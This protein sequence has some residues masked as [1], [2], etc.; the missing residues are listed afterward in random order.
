MAVADQP[1]SRLRDAAEAELAYGDYWCRQAGNAAHAGRT[2]DETADLNLAISQLNSGLVTVPDDIAGLFNLAQAY[3]RMGLIDQQR[4]DRERAAADFEHAAAD[5][6]KSQKIDDPL[7]MQNY[8]A[9]LDRV[10]YHRYAGA[11]AG[12]GE[13]YFRN[14]VESNDQSDAVTVLLYSLQFFKDALATDPTVPEAAQYLNIIQRDLME[15]A[16]KARAHEAAWAVLRQ[17]VQALAD[18]NINKSSVTAADQAAHDVLWVLPKTHP[19][20]LFIQAFRGD[21][22]SYLSAPS[23]SAAGE[24]RDSAAKLLKAWKDRNLSADAVNDAMAAAMCYQG[25]LTAD[26][27]SGQAWNDLRSQADILAPAPAAQPPVP[28]AAEA[29]RVALSVLDQHRAA[30]QPA[31][32]PTTAPAGQ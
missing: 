30:T 2:A 8:M 6:Y 16:A 32:Q 9:V 22:Q 29:L 18:G 24:V 17:K 27:R 4:A 10:P 13:L 26:E 11:L 23:T 25:V 21:L 5:E 28:G 14:I 20:G 3:Q 31:T 1:H 19:L 7:A 12:I 15:Q